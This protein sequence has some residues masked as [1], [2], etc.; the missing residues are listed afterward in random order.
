MRSD[1]DKIRED[2]IREYGEGTRHLSF[3]G[4]L[5]TDRTHFIFELLQNA[6]DAGAS[7]IIFDLFEDRLEVSHNGRVFDEKDVRGVCGVGEGTKTEDLTQIG[8]FGIGFKSVYAYTNKPEIHSGDENFKIENYVR[9]YVAPQ[10]TVGKD[11]TTLF[12]F[13]FNS[14]KI[15][16]KT[17][18]KEIGDRLLNLSDRTLLFLRNINEIEYRL[19]NTTRG[20]YLREGKSRGSAREITVIGE[21]NDKYEEE[22]W[23]IFSRP[24]TVP[25]KT[26]TVRVEISFRL[27]TEEKNGIKSERVSRVK[28]SPLYV[29]FPTEKETRLGF[30]IQGP[31]RTTPSRDNIPS[32]DMWNTTLVRET[33]KLI[34]D[35]LPE[36][37]DLGLLSVSF[38]EALPVRTDDF[39]DYTMLYPIYES[40]RNALIEEELLPADDG[41]FVSAKNAKLARGA[42]LRNLLRQSQLKQLFQTSTTLKWLSGEIRE[43]QTRDLYTYLIKELKVEEVDPESFARKLDHSFLSVQTDEWFVNFYKFLSVQ[44]ALWRAPR[45]KNDQFGIL[46]TKPILR[47]ESGVQEIPFKRDG[48]TPKAY[49]PPDEETMFPVVKRFIVK[50]EHA[51]TFLKRLGLSEPDI[52]DNLV[53]SIL[54]KYNELRERTISKVERQEDMRIIVHALASESASGKK[55]LIEAAKQTPFLYVTNPVG[56]TALK[57]PTEVY[58]NTPKLRRYFGNV[59]DVWFLHDEY[60]SYNIDIDILSEFGVSNLPRK[61]KVDDLPLEEREYSTRDEIIDNY[62]LHGL[63]QFLRVIEVSTNFDKQKSDAYLLWTFLQEY[64]ERDPNFFRAKYQWFYHSQ[65]EKYFISTI[66]VQLKEAKWI[67]TK[68]HSIKKPADIITEQLFDEFS[69]MPELIQN[70]GIIEG[71]NKIQELYAREYAEALGM[72]LDDI[73]FLKNHR[74]EFNKFKF[75][76]IALCA[77]IK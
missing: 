19:P 43:N 64:L 74:E 71:N 33:A 68:D 59:Q 41:S 39:S 54:P 11:L 76:L 47:L 63:K 21:N 58:F 30:L 51:V 53:L 57:K 26:K 42:E 36:I 52:Y 8:K 5:Y 13:P 65:H 15:T 3:L 67:P 77:N 25:D 49:L 45:W 10:K 69:G 27:E 18:C 70:L 60:T 55:R 44:E 62:D 34:R 73:E 24:V 20:E 17:A 48:I 2:N 61:M 46:R 37:K 14:E 28:S 7:R 12:V 4:H 56:K 23:L 35:V 50:D 32:S 6:E 31:Y 1:Y 72:T 75:S 29:Y 66:L 9:P 16:P 40:V 22:R 38:L